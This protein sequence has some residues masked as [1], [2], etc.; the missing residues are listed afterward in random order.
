LAFLCLITSAIMKKTRL[1][2]LLLCFSICTYAQQ[3]TTTTAH[4]DSVV[5]T[6]RKALLVNASLQY[7]SNLTYAG[8]KDNSSVPILLPTVT[9]VSKTGLFLSSSGYFNVSDRGSQSEGLSIT[10]GYVFWFDKDKYYGGAVSATKYFITSNSPIILSSFDGTFDGQLFAN[11]G[12]IVKL[13]VS[14]SYRLD[15]GGAHDWINEA[16]LSKEIQIIKLSDKRRH[17]FKINPTLSL[18]SGTQ[19]FNQSYF[20]NS[21]VPTAVNKAVTTPGTTTTT[22][23]G[24][25]TGILGVLFPP[26]TITTTSPSTTSIEQTIVDET[27]TEQKEQEVRKYQVLAG[28]VSMPITYTIYKKLQ[29]VGTPYFIKPFNQVTYANEAPRNGLYFLFIVGANITF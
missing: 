16:D 27:V 2:L 17:A 20:V 24:G 14:G 5:T 1:F 6:K 9:L 28:S 15:K 12:N 7:I 26:T 23:T 25:G 13:A 29:L 8:V 21:V 18:Y 4:P 10:P 11:P 22:T 19:S 3:T